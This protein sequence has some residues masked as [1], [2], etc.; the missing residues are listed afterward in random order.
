M[1]LRECPFCGE[2]K[3]IEKFVDERQFFSD[4][5]V[6]CQN[7]GTLGPPCGT[8]EQAQKMWNERKP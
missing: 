4:T 7:C 8:W 1:K 3:D 2:E 6:R 5:C